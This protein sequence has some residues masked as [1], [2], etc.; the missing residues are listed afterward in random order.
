MQQVKQKIKELRPPL[1]VVA[2]MSFYICV[3]FAILNLVLGITLVN[4]PE[5]GGLAIVGKYTP[6]W[7]YGVLFIALGVLGAWT[8]YKNN[9]RWIRRTLILG[10]LYKSIWFYALLAVW[11]KGGSPAILSLW[12]FLIYVQAM[13]YIFFI[14]THPKKES[15][16]GSPARIR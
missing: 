12:L 10:M 14:P 4:T 16:N 5:S 3:G 11:L 9:W 7:A 13:T 15:P 8:L 6:I 2:P 1:R